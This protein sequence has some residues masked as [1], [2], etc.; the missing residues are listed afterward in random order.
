MA[1]EAFTS[2]A[3]AGEKV[4]GAEGVK[5]A[6]TKKPQERIREQIGGLKKRQ[7]QVFQGLQGISQEGEQELKTL[8]VRLQ[9]LEEMGLNVQGLR[10]QIEAQWGE[11]YDKQ[12]AKLQEVEAKITQLETELQK[13][14]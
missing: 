6:E 2:E 3:E 14:N 8:L 7:S 1:E 5:E 12:F 9:K 13:T 11:A 10:E 4:E